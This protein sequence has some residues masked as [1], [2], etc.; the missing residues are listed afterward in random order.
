M[1]RQRIRKRYYKTL[2]TSVL[3]SPLSPSCLSKLQSLLMKIYPNIQDKKNKKDRIMA[4]NFPC[5]T[6]SIN[7]HLLSFVSLLLERTH[8]GED[9]LIRNRTPVI[10][11]IIWILLLGKEHSGVDKLIRNGTP[12]I[13]INLIFRKGTQWCG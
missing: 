1:W 4:V 8:I 7:K 2:G 11:I 5:C 12:V 9:K 6:S 13:K 3:N 10:I